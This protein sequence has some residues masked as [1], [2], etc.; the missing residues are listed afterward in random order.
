MFSTYTFPL[1]PTRERKSKLGS[2]TVRLH[3]SWLLGRAGIAN[4]PDNGLV[5]GTFTL[6]SWSLPTITYALPY[7][8]WI[9]RNINWTSSLAGKCGKC[10]RQ[11][12]VY[13]RFRWC[14]LTSRARHKVRRDKRCWKCNLIPIN[15]NVCQ[16]VC[17]LQ[18]TKTLKPSLEFS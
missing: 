11:S 16:C 17:L 5:S 9:I 1:S 6:S 15:V 14:S 2:C 10:T 3:T 7:P 12:G 18:N 8:W 13:D 4:G